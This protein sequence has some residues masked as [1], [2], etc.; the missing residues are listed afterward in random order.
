MERLGSEQPEF[1]KTEI[2]DEK[3]APEFVKAFG[4]LGVEKSLRPN[5]EKSQ[6]EKEKFFSGEI[7]NPSFEYDNLDIDSVR[8]AEEDLLRLKNEILE[9]EKNETLAQ[10]YRWR[11]NEM[12]A[13][14]RMLASSHNKDMRRFTRYSTYV[15]GKPSREYF[16]LSIDDIRRKLKKQKENEDPDIKKAAEKLNLLLPEASEESSFPPK[17]TEETIIALHEIFQEE[18]DELEIEIREEDTYTTEEVKS[19]F[20]KALEAIGAEKWTVIID[21]DTLSIDANQQEETLYLP[22][23]RIYKGNILI[24][25]IMHEIRRHVERRVKGEK[26]SLSLLAFGLDRYEK[27]EEGVTKVTEHGIEKK[28]KTFATPELH[29][30]VGLAIGTDGQPRNFREV[31]EILEKHFFLRETRSGTEKGEARETAREKAWKHCIRV[32]R[33]SDCKTRGACFTKDIVYREG[34]IAIWNL[35]SKDVNEAYKFTMGK[36]DPSNERHLWIL[37]QLGISDQNL[38]E[39]EQQP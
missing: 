29:L 14:A 8:A 24:K 11:I 9:N 16:E 22:P 3:W 38:N 31:F 36:Y 28:F 6:V 27:G 25:K 32:F 2:I 17:P 5:K 7:E 19:L 39:L 35:V 18:Y 21:K 34:A 15:Y 10:A 26:S 12:I 33:G 13:R 30:A 23:E 37:S 20:E 4:H 1:K